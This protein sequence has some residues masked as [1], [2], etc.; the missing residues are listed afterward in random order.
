MTTYLIT[1]GLGFI[2]FHLAMKLSENQ[3][4]RIII[5]DAKKHFIPK[6]LS[7]WEFYI[8]Y[9]LEKLSKKQNIK[10]INGNCNN[11]D[12]LQKTI[13]EYNPHKIIHLAALPIAGISNDN[14]E[15]AKIDIF[16]NT[17]N[18]L[19]AIKQSKTI[20]EKLIY[21]SSSMVYGNFK[22]N[23]KNEIIPASENQFCNPIGL[24]GVMKLN[25][26]NLVRTYYHRFNIPYTIV[27]PSAVYG[28]TDSN[29]RVTEI[30]VNRS[31]SGKEIILD[32]GGKHQLDFTFIDDLIKGLILVS[33]SKK[34]FCE[35]FNISYGKGVSIKDLALT[36]KQFIPNTKIIEGTILP[37]RPNRGSLDINKA[38]TLLGYKPEFDIYSGV[39]KYIEFIKQA[40]YN[41]NETKI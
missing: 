27:R 20:P 12:L 9:R 7:Q 34:S 19:E 30:F 21:V 10:I 23:S 4:N 31:L 33:D 22:R 37:Y 16:D 40:K 15:K 13:K 18:L 8:K 6:Y 25:A 29:L 26:E 11:T 3:S 32:N 39:K 24:Y 17:L 14:P 2:G 35:T 5:F 41:N 36:I 38:K 1:G 28:P